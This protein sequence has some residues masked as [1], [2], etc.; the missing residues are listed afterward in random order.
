MEAE[1]QVHSESTP[2]AAVTGTSVIAQSQWP[3]GFTNSS[4]FSEKHEPVLNTAGEDLLSFD[5]THLSTFS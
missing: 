1:T 3:S 4:N 2:E 5:C